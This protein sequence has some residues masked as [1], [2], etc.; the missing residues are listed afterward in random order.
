MEHNKDVTWLREIK[1]GM[2]GKNKQAQVQ[3]LQEKLKKILKKIPNWKDPGL[4]GVQG[5]WLKN[6]TSLQKN[7]VWHLN[8]CLDGETP[9][10][11]TKRRTVLI[12]KDKSKGNEAN[13]YCPIT[14]LPFA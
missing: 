13:N 10:W 14:C 4:D 8:A 11:M 3:I 6:F 7:L 12:Q 9:W 1:K 2:N 5:F